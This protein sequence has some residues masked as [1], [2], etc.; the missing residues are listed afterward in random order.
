MNKSISIL[1]CGWLGLPLAEQLLK[2]G[3]NVKG[4]TTTSSKLDVLD[5]KNI[6]PFFLEADPD[7]RGERC[8]QFFQSKVLF[9]NIPFRRNLENPEVYLQQIR[10]VMHFVRC[11]PIEQIIFCSSTSVYSSQI[12]IASENDLIVPENERSKILLQIEEIFLKEWKEKL[13][14]LRLAGLYGKNRKIGNFLSG[15]KNLKL[16]ESPVNLIHL[17]DCV[18]LI[19]K[20]IQQKVVGEVFNVCSDEHPKRR[21]LYTKAAQNLKVDPPDFLDQ[22]KGAKKIV[23]NEKMKKYF[24]YQF[25]HPDPMGDV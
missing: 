1:G 17:D 12:N 19:L 16:G 20:I 22:L 25:I 4:S 18:A 24:S 21:D 14:V 15:K 2:R 7:I 5:K 9:L 23:S 13:V 10:S 3:F 6:E 11:S 8:D